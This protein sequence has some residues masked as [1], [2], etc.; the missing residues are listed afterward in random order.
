[1]KESNKLLFPLIYTCITRN[2][3]L[4]NFFATILYNNIYFILLAIIVIFENDVDYLIKNYNL[5][6]FTL[7]NVF[8]FLQWYEIGYIINDTFSVKYEKQ[9]T[10]RLNFNLTTKY[11]IKFIGLRIILTFSFF[12]IAFLLGVDYYL[13]IGTFSGYLITII[14]FLLHNF[15]KNVKKRIVTFYLLR[16]FKYFTTLLPLWFYLDR[17]S[18]IVFILLISFYCVYYL[19]GYLRSKNLKYLRLN[20][21]NIEIHLM[22]TSVVGIVI[23]MLIFLFIKKWLLLI[24]FSIMY[25]ITFLLIRNIIKKRK[26]ASG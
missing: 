7:I 13:I 4:L 26:W 18:K 24:F 2:K 8:V 3:T 14:I 16:F 19:N 11:F 12:I 9:P 6:I 10:K 20:E 17:Y 1:M 21:N 23:F 5:I 15:L 25:Y 22:V